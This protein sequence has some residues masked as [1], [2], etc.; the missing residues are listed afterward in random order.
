M[1]GWMKC[2]TLKQLLFRIFLI[3]VACLWAYK[4]KNSDDILLIPIKKNI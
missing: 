4:N 1:L 3:I 2:E